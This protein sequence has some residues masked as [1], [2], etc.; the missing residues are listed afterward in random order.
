M[1]ETTWGR[2]PVT[3]VEIDQPL[4]ANT[5]GTAPCTAAIGVTGTIKCFNTFATCQDTA[6]FDGSSEIVWRFC[7]PQNGAAMEYAAIP[8]LRS[9]SSTPTRLNITGQSKTSGALGERATVTIQ[10]Q[11]HPDADLTAD[12]YVDGRAYDP[13]ARGTFWS[14]WLARNPYHVNWSI[15]IRDGYMGEAAA[16]MRTRHFIV[17]KIEGPN[18]AGIVTLK[19]TDV[20]KLTDARRA[21]APEVSRGV[22]AADLN[23]SATSFDVV[24]AVEADY[25]ATGT[26]VI[27]GEV[28]TYTGRSETSGVITFTGVTRGTDNTSATTHSADDTVQQCLRYSAENVVDVI[29]DLLTNHTDGAGGFIDTAGFTAERSWLSVVNLT[30][31]ITEPTG[32]DKLLAEICE[33]ALCFIWWDERDQ[34]IKLKALRPPTETP[35]E[36]SEDANIIANSQSLKLADDERAT[37]V[38]VF[39]ARR[40][41]TEKLDE[42]SNY[43]R[44]RIRIDADAESENAYGD[45]RIRKI[46]SRWIQ[47]DSIALTLAARLITRYSDTPRYMRFRCDAKDRSLWTADVV[48]VTT[49]LI[50]DETGSPAVWRGQIIRAEEVEPGHI[51]EYDALSYEFVGRFS[52]IMENAA[53]DFASATD[54]AKIDGCWLA[55]STGLMPDGSPGYQLQ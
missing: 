23:A 4:C 53:P 37:Q 10:F 27:N 8:S 1:S 21:Q 29:E 5:Y 25:D 32:V 41:P 19:A 40:N 17:E 49:R 26:L 14:K 48:D 46:Y 12:P 18:S 51:V 33:Q 54:A 38:W 24:G 47:Q 35:T 22:L 44:V 15:R 31:L 36:I 50:V 55:E 39:Y 34:K 30:T 6:N 42:E 20:L 3:L 9:V 7:T 28:M 13:L 43:A 16:S 45:V 11:D 52:F 2:E